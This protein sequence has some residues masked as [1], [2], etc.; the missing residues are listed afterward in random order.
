[1]QQCMAAQLNHRSALARGHRDVVDIGIQSHVHMLLSMVPYHAPPDSWDWAALH[2]HA[3]GPCFESGTSVGCMVYAAHNFKGLHTCLCRTTGWLC[4][5]SHQVGRG[6]RFV[7]LQGRR[8]QVHCQGCKEHY[9]I[10]E[11]ACL[12]RH[13]TQLHMSRLFGR[14]RSSAGLNRLYNIPSQHATSS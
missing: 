13:T 1:M 3:W 8:H 2:M 11:N 7:C 12:L 4:V 10:P 5:G 14:F 9:D 6:T